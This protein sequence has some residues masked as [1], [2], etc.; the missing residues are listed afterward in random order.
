MRLQDYDIQSK[1]KATVIDSQ[2]ITSHQAPEVRAITL[3]TQ[4]ASLDVSAGQNV[5]V[6]VAGRSEFGQENHLRLYSIADVPQETDEG[7]LR[8][9]LCVRR[10]TYID[11]YSGEEYRGLA[12][13][14]LCDLRPGDSLT[15]TGPYGP[16]FEIPQDREATVILIGAGTGI[17]PFRALVKQ[18]YQSQPPFQGRVW[19]FY[20]AQTGLELLYMNDIKNDFAQ[21]YDLKTFEAFAALSSRPHWSQAIDWNSAFQSPRRRTVE[22]ALGSSYPRVRGRLGGHSGRTRFRIRKNRGVKKEMGEAEG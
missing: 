14:F 22:H 4:K 19:L 15:L 9:Q 21:Y 3:E 10:C 8:I 1:V 13:N 12:S 5:G 16:A 11:E 20:G 2:R 7:G 17:A 18:L 6:L